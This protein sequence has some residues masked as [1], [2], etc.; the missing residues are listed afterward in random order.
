MSTASGAFYLAGERH[1]NMTAEMAA[2][3]GLPAAPPHRENYD[4]ESELVAH[5]KRARDQFGYFSNMASGPSEDDKKELLPA[6]LPPQYRSRLN[7]QGVPE[8]KEYTLVLGFNGTLVHTEW[9][10]QFG[11]R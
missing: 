11:S 8:P 1:Q 7:A 4:D 3:M 6:M 5:A 9:S 10:A 2:E